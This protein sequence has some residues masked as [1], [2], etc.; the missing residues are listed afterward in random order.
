MS[1]LILTNGDTASDLLTAAGKQGHIVP[2]RDSLN[3]GPLGPISTLEE[4]ANFRTLR[5]NYWADRGVNEP[6]ALEQNY[7]T[8]DR[9]LE[10]H[11]AYSSIELWFEHD[12]YDQLQLI[13]ILTRLYHLKRFDQVFLIQAETYLGMQQPDSIL[14]LE[15]LSLPVSEQMMAIADLAW[16]TVAHETPKKLAEFITLKPAGFPFLRQALTR[17][18][19]E[20]PGPDGLSRTQ[21]QMLYSL[22]RGVNRPGMLF[23]RCQAMEEAQFW[24]DLGFFD[25]LSK[26]QFC[27][28]PLIEGLPFA[29]SMQVFQDSETRK[30]FIQSQLTLTDL[31]QEILTGTADHADHNEIEYHLG[32]THIRSNNLWRWDWKEAVLHA[33]PA[34]N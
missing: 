11:M 4:Q 26:L 34:L 9:L 24:G 30:S 5:A 10:N 27:T 2:W 29:S 22:S 16:Q 19:E 28:A 33:P 6:S 32:G 14:K 12:L 1:A 18:L 20:L 3:E 8:R 17:L 31:G 23:G 13:E 15:S 25:V 21:R 7:Q